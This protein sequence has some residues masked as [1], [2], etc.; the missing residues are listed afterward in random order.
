M[1]GL[2]RT[3]TV[4]H[5]VGRTEHYMAPD[6]KSGRQTWVSLDREVWHRLGNPPTITVTIE[7]GDALNDPT[8]P[9]FTG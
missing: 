3:L 7:A 8:H 2:D 5:S 6:P 9:S 1:S 4:L